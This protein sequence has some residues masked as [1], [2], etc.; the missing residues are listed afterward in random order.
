[1]HKL[2]SALARA[3]YGLLHPRPRYGKSS[4]Q[5]GWQAANFH[6]HY[7][8]A[9]RL[10]GVPR[11]L[12]GVF[13]AA[14]IGYIGL[15]TAPSAQEA[16]AQTPAALEAVTQA[17]S[18]LS[19]APPTTI[20]A[21]TTI[22][23]TTIT[24]EITGCAALTD[25]IDRSICEL[26]QE[27]QK[28]LAPLDPAQIEAVR[29]RLQQQQQAT[30]K[31]LGPA[32]NLKTRSLT[33]DLAPGRRVEDLYLAPGVVSTISILDATGQPW[34][35]IYAVAG[36]GSSFDLKQPIA[37]GHF[38]TIQQKIN[39]VN[40]HPGNLNIALKNLPGLLTYRL[41]GGSMEV[42][43]PQALAPIIPNSDLGAGDAVMTAILDG[44]APQGAIALSIESQGSLA[45]EG[46]R[47]WQIGERLYVRTSQPDLI[48]LSPAWQ[49][50]VSALGGTAH[51]YQLAPTPVLVMSLAGRAI[52]IN[53][54]QSLQGNKDG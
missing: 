20:T 21:P 4:A 6:S 26:F 31:P 12:A 24:S 2:I 22:A 19:G 51:A 36:D 28:D 35:I 25:K 9:R 34:P 50:S 45:L 38:L 37:E 32:P 15:F 11:R 42:Y 16:Q 46:V 1:M 41:V 8:K 3:G 7:Q 30:A 53:L 33:V 49:Q 18:P 23:P 39:F 29:R 5:P 17:A 13:C 43:G 54:T 44:V 52:S 27:G 14:Y 47:A 40:N 10:A 48:L